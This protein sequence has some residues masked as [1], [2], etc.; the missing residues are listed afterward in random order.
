MKIVKV[1]LVLSVILVSMLSAGCYKTMQPMNLPQNSPAPAAT[2]APSA[3]AVGAVILAMGGM[4]GGMV[5][6]VNG[7]TPV[8]GATV[9]VNSVTFTDLGGGSYQGVLTGP[10]NTGDTITLTITSSAGNIT[11]SGAV[12]ATGGTT[13]VAIS[14]AAAGSLLSISF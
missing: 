11:A 2:A 1:L 3:F 7:A 14:G 5:T 12:P 9:V 10:F 4:P 6:L 13:N 8:T